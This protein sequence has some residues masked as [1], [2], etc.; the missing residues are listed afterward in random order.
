MA[1]VRVLLGALALVAFFACEPAKQVEEEPVVGPTA[2]L[3]VGKVGGDD[4]TVGDIDDWIKDQ[5]F[6]QA[7]RG[8]NPMKVYEVRTRA[9]EQM[10]NE[11]AMERAATRAGKDKDTLLKEEVE[12]RAS[13]SDEEVQKYYDEHKDRFRNLP[14]EKVSPAVKRQLLAQKQVAAMQEYTKSLREEIGFESSLEPPRFEIAAS[15]PAKGPAD[16]PITLIE[17]S[18]YECPFCKASENVVKQVLERYPTQVKL[19]FKHY[20]LP[21]HPKA[22]PAAEAALCAAEQGKFW[23]FHSLLFQNAPQIAP[24]QL[25]GIANAAGLDTPKWQ[26]CIAAK[27]N[28]A[29]IDA[30]LEVGKSAGVAGTPAFYVNGVPVSGGRTVDDFA[31]AI[32]AELARLGLPVPPPPAKPA[33]AQTPAVAPPVAVQPA[34]PGAPTAPAPAAPDAAPAAPPAAAPQAADDGHG[35]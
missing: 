10:A 17:F 4:V 3:V 25:V 26:E 31:K 13:V 9:L 15:G 7:T 11:R 23:E 5:L 20:P 16:A 8:A 27:R 33:A 21:T 19:V 1:P 32:D 12:K 2:D 34:P 14:F 35:H 28:S 24:E 30:D 18:D 6:N 22:R 29:Q